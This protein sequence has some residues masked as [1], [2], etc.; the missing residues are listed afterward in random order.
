V[1]SPALANALLTVLVDR[2]V[3]AKAKELGVVYTRYIDDLTFSGPNAR[4]LINEAAVRLSALR[5]S[6]HRK[7]NK[8]K[9]VANHSLQMVTGLVVNPRKRASAGRKR[10]DNVKVAIYQFAELPEDDRPHA[11]ESIRG[12]ITYVRQFNQGA[13]ARLKRRFQEAI[14]VSTGTRP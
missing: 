3:Q 7:K 10:I 12:R 14:A 5:L 8:L 6:I 11:I 13:A 1:I 2:P 4:E 9:I